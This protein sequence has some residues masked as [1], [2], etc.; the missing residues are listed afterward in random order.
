MISVKV[1]REYILPLSTHTFCY[2]HIHNNVQ[3]EVLFKG[4]FK[5]S[6]SKQAFLPIF[7][8]LPVFSIVSF[9]QKFTLL[10][11]Y[12]LFCRIGNK[13]ISKN[14]VFAYNCEYHCGKSEEYL[15]QNRGNKSL[16]E[17]TRIQY[18]FV[19][20]QAQNEEINPCRSGKY[21]STVTSEMVAVQG[22]EPRTLRI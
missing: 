1:I 4:H 6:K 19:S 17:V 12:V 9:K 20:K 22:F 10:D 3:M 14:D 21:F 5:I 18:N 16:P 2:V 11:F 7:N 13:R 15:V 8:T